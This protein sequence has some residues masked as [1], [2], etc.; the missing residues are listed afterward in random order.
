MDGRLRVASKRGEAIM[1]EVPI[2]ALREVL[3][4]MEAEKRIL[5]EKNDPR[6]HGV[7]FR[8][9]AALRERLSSVEKPEPGLKIRIS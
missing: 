1:I 2:D 4:Y 3:G 9:V 7:V 6:R 5:D 8:Q